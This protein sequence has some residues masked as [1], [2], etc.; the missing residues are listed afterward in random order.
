MITKSRENGMKVKIYMYVEEEERR[1][2]MYDCVRY[3]QWRSQ[4]KVLGGGGLSP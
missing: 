1:T 4:K 3:M 2:K